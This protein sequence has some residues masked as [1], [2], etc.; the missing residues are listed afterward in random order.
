MPYLLPCTQCDRKL[1]VDTS[2]A[3]E[4]IQCVCG[5]SV[6]V[7][8]L[9]GIRELE[10]S[11]T[12]PGGPTPRGWDVRRG[13]VFAVGAVIAF[14]GIVAVLFAGL[15]RLNAM[16]GERPKEDLGP[17][18]ESIDAMGP[19]ETLETWTYVREQG[20]GPYRMSGYARVREVERQLGRIMVV[21]LGVIVLGVL[22]IAAAWWLPK[23]TLT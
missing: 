17:V 2:Q 10:A 9:R 15:G 6:E 12:V 14:G 19:A 5:A 18:F 21:G 13:V 23:S 1:T 20:L 11:Q 3:G 22:I 8:S 7:P 4:Q 16:P